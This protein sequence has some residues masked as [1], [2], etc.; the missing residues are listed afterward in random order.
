MIKGF[1]AENGIDL[2]DDMKA[3]TDAD[4]ADAARKTI[5]LKLSSDKKAINNLLGK[6]FNDMKGAAQYL[7]KFYKNNA[8]KL[9]LWSIVMGANNQIKYP[10]D[11]QGKVDMVSA[12]WTYHASFP[13]G[14]SPLQNYIDTNSIDAPT[15]IANIASAVTAFASYK[16]NVILSEQKRILRDDTFITAWEHTKAIGNFLHKLNAH[17]PKDTCNWGFN[18]IE[19]SHVQSVRKSKLTIGAKLTVSG[20]VLDTSFTN[21][22]TD[23]LYLFKGKKATGTPNIVHSGE[24]FVLIHGYS[25][26]TVSNPSPTTAGK[27]EVTINK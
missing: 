6:P 9:K 17:N 25:S 13:V 4:T 27:F 22:G 15:Y 23:D 5:T 10:N 19:A 18:I 12:F 24:H 20:T 7:K 21:T 11:D 14:T 8:T 1:L 3:K 2:V 16:Q 26:I